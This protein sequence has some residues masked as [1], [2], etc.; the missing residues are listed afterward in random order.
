MRLSTLLTTSLALTLLGSAPAWVHA[1]APGE[2]QEAARA[3]PVSLTL[4][5]P[6]PIADEVIVRKAERRLYLLRNGEVFRSYH[7]ALG[8]SPSGAKERAGDFR[9]PEGRYQLTRR[10]AR[11]DYFLSIQ[12]SYPNEDD[13]RRAR[14]ARVDPGGAI[15]LHGLPNAPRHP[16][17]FYARADWTDGCIALSDSDMVEVW[18]M[19][20]DN[21]PIEI[22]P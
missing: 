7:V 1:D 12:V 15:M 21:I 14:V 20:Q 16:L 11:S 6:V 18:L 4:S 2:T 8:L 13:L 10:N 22:L 9:T 3:E 17:D 5:A 19:T